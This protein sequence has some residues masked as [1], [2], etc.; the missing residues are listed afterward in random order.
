MPVFTA[1]SHC[2]NLSAFY[3]HLSFSSRG[4]YNIHQQTNTVWASHSY[5]C[6]IS[7]NK[8]VHTRA[9]LYARSHICTPFILKCLSQTDLLFC[10]PD[11]FC[12]QGNNSNLVF[13]ILDVLLAPD[14]QNPTS[15]FCYSHPVSQMQRLC[16]YLASNQ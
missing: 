2:N 6:L 4:R 5:L 8:R 10:V 13:V 11:D 15:L 9:G 12:H 16:K 7:A 3:Q 14:S 1:G